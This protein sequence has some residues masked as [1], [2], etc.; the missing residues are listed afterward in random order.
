[1]AP[2]EAAA[3][4]ILSALAR[5]TGWAI[6]DWNEKKM[7]R[8]LIPLLMVLK[9]HVQ[10]DPEKAPCG[11]RP[12]FS[13]STSLKFHEPFEVQEGE[14]PWQVSI[15]ISQKHLCGGSIIHQWWV[16]TAAHCFPRTLLE[17]ALG[18]VTVVMGTRTFSNVHLER[19]RV[20]KIVIHKDYKPSHLDSDLSLLLLATPI[21]FTNF[22]MPV[23]L[24]KKEKIWD[25]CWMAEWVTDNGY[26]D[27][28]TYLQ[29]LRVVQI[30]WKECSKR[31]DQ[32]SRNMLCAW[33]EPG[34]K[35]NCQGDSG[36]PMI[37]TMRG[38]KRVFQVGVF[39][40]G[41]RSGFRGRPGMFVSVA[42]FI[43]WIQEETEK[44]GKAYTISGAQRSSLPHVPQYPLLL[45]LGVSNA[46]YYHV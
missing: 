5:S 38:T 44:E 29:K 32:L 37:C 9:G 23:C 3:A 11:Y 13:N 15:Q 17:M 12:A 8:L 30:N 36:A 43:P 7:L 22:K 1:M 19:K 14:F 18:N 26:D 27:L 35:G 28:N 16:L 25:R 46:A 24:Q 39:S 45:G 6:L 2:T 21:Q 34:T 42:Q 4:G 40:W 41:K 10:E 33:K 20:R 31:V